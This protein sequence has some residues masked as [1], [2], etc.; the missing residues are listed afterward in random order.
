LFLVDAGV[1]PPPCPDPLEDWIRLPFGGQ[2]F[3]LRWQALKERARSRPFRP[4]LDGHGRLIRDGAWVALSPIEER[5]LRSMIEHLGDVLTED[6]LRR[7]AWPEEQATSTALRIQVSRLRRRIAPLRLNLR[8]VRG[9][10]YV[11]EAG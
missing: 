6:E 2:E 4:H 7:A 8:T 3:D 1:E 9:R 5:L 11:L 10:G